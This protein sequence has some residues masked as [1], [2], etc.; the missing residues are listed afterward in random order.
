MDPIDTCLKANLLIDSVPEVILVIL[1]PLY[2]ECMFG[3]SY[4]SS[5]RI[6]LVSTSNGYMRR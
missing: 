6:D 3:M 2:I 1:V 5:K 4:S